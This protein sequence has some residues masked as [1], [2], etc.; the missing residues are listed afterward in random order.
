M[1]KRI[2]LPL[3]IV[4]IAIIAF[5][6]SRKSSG[7][8][9]EIFTNVKKGQ[10]VVEITTTGELKAARSTQIRGPERARNYRINSM[11]IE[12]MVDEG[13]V[14]RE[15]D[16]VALLDRS[17]LF[18]RISDAQ[19]NLDREL[20]QYEQTQLDTA[21]TLRTERDKIVN[22]QYAVEERKLILEQS[23]FEPPATIRQNEI[24]LDRAYRDLEQARESYVIKSQQSLAKM[25]EVTARLRKE[26]REFAEMQELLQEFTIYAPQAG[27]VIYEKG[28]DGSRI[29]AGS[30]VS[31]WSPVVATLPDLT[32]MQSITYVNEV[33]IRK[34]KIGQDVKIGLDA[35]PDKKLTG[36]VT[37]VS[38]VG[39][40]NP[41][42]DAKV[43]EVTIRVNE[44][45]PS[46]RPAMTTSN[47][48]IAEEKMDVM[49]VPLEALHAEA[50]SINYV[51]KAN[52]TK[53]EVEVGLS[54]NNE[55][56]IIQGL[57]EGDKVYLSEPTR[58]RDKAISLLPSME[59]RRR[60]KLELAPTAPASQPS[61]MQTITLPDGRQVQMTPEMRQRMQNGGGNGQRPQNGQSQPTGGQ[62]PG[63]Q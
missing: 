63:G 50:D 60:E 31:T 45:D 55:I 43:F 26:Q 39:Q 15:G 5:V 12:N 10:F 20:A 1:K 38:N 11:K 33:D 49:Y 28:F 14:V 18:N 48:I 47:V 32:V 24:A 59:G 9:R 17:E 51:Y 27:M 21:L 61:D 42:S 57:T 56:I 23:K 36:K 13:T 40:Q 44:T 62:R 58:F 4:F 34:V 41:N 37:R 25:Q 54:N 30:T 6:V 8:E 53:Q 29:M 19:V 35:F 52:G 7:D 22:L 3:A 46:L 16:F 2:I